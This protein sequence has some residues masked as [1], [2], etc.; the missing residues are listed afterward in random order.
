MGYSKLYLSPTGAIFFSAADAA[1][2]SLVGAP[3]AANL[4]AT[5]MIAPFWST[6]DTRYSGEGIFASTTSAG[7]VDYVTF[8]FLATPTSGNFQTPPSA[9][10]AR[11][12][13]DGS[14]QFQYGANLDG[15]AATIGLSAGAQNNFALA[16]NSGQTNLA[17][18]ASLLFTPDFNK[19]LTYF[20]IGAIEFQG[21]SN[22]SALPTI[23]GVANLP[24]QGGATDAVFTSIGLQFSAPL[25]VI[26]AVSAANYQLVAAGADGVFGTSDDIRIALTP[27]YSSAT[28]SV[29]LAL[30][31][32]PLADG[33]YQLTV[34]GSGQLID[35]SGNPL[36]GAGGGN[37]AS[38]FVRLFSVDR[39]AVQPPV[40]LNG[41]GTTPSNATISV[42]LSATDPQGLALTYA[43][44]SAPQHG[45]IQNFDPVAGTFTY[46]PDVGYVG[47]DTILFSAIDSKL[48]SA[49]GSVTINVTAYRN[50]PVA[51]DESAS[52]IAT[53]PTAI[54]LGAYDAQIPVS[55]LKL[56]I[57][58]GPAHGALTITGQN[59][60]SYVAAAGYNGADAFSYVWIDDTI[61]PALQSAPATVSIAVTSVNQPPVTGPTTIA[62]V[63]NKAYV[64]KLADFPYSDPNNA[65]ST[66]LS[67]V[68]VASL[69]N[70]A[71]GALSDNGVA[72]VAGAK[73]SAADIA[74]GKLVFTPAAGKFGA[75]AASFA[76]E[77]VNSGGGQNASAPAVATIDIAYVNQA[78]TTGD[79]HLSV[80]AGSSLTLTSARFPFSDPNTPPEALAG[81]VITSG[82]SAGTLTLRVNGVST[83]VALNQLI[84]KAQLDAGD[85][86]FT[87]AGAGGSSASFGFAVVDVG[88]VANGGH[89]QSAAATVTIDVLVAGDRAPTTGPT[90][91][92][93]YQNRPYV[94]ALADF[95]YSDATDTSPTALKAVIMGTLPASGALTLGGVAVT[96]GQAIA[97]ADIAA[98]KLVYT[99]APNQSGLGLASFSFAV[100]DSGGLAHGG[101]DTSAPAVASVNVQQR[102]VNGDGSYTISYVGPSGA[103][104][105]YYTV[106]YSAAGKSISAVYSD[107]ETAAWT[108]DSSGKL[109]DVAYA[110]VTAASYNSYDVVYRA[111]GR[112]ASASYSD[113]MTATFNYDVAGKLHDIAYAGVTGASYNSYDVV[114]AKGKQVSASYSDGMTAAWSYNGDGSLHDVAYSG[115]V[116]AGYNAYDVLYGADG[117]KVS[118]TYSNGMTAAWTYNADGSLHDVAYA[119]VTGASYNAYDLVYGF[120]GR[121][122]S[123]TYSNGMTVAWTYNANGTTHDVAYAGVYGAAYSSYDIVYGANGKQASASYANGMTQTW[124][125]NSNGALHDLAY[126]GVKGAAYVSY[127][128][129]YGANGRQSSASYANGM[130]Q[131]WSYSSQGI[132]LHVAYA[133]VT[134]AAYASY[135]VAYGAN[136]REASATYS[137]GMTQTWTY[138]SNGTLHDLASAKIGGAPGASSDI[139][140]GAN[141]R[142][143]S[144]TYS[145]G[146]TTQWN[147]NADGTFHDVVHAGIY[148][149]AYVSYDVVYDSRGRQASAIYSNGMTATWTYNADGSVHDIAYANVPG[150]AYTSY[151]VLYGAS[152]KPASATYSNGMTATW[153]YTAD[154]SLHDVA[155]AHVTGLPYDAYDVVYG[156]NGKPVSSTY[157]NSVTAVWSYNADGTR[158]DIAYSG[159]KGAAYTSYDVVYGADGKAVSATF[160]N[161][162]TAAW[163]YHVAGGYSVLYSISGTVN[164]V[165][166][167][168]FEANFDATR[169][170]KTILYFD[171]A[172][173][174]VARYTY[175]SGGK[176]VFTLGET[177]GEVDDAAP[178][179]IA[180]ASALT[181]ETAPPPAPSVT[182]A[183]LRFDDALMFGA[184]STRA[185]PLVLTGALG[186]AP[187]RAEIASAFFLG[188]VSTLAYAGAAKA[189]RR[190]R[191]RLDLFDPIADRWLPLEEED[192]E[193]DALFSPPADEDA[194][195]WHVVG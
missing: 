189:N 32:G 69:P 41:S 28:D 80:V 12:G 91:I 155:Y 70:A 122:V 98:G 110:G 178:E 3:S 84:T 27:I 130:T 192:P 82:P 120:N 116:G 149:A 191:A 57:I 14:V 171:A 49:Q 105:A 124:S 135:D 44:V 45:A 17:N 77:V 156:P 111:D 58:T 137:N 154:G 151:D 158:H 103:D 173:K 96:A 177:S 100:Q 73:I 132:L 83:A 16:A 90:T 64:F 31:G 187:S 139:I 85:L 148:G 133:G 184:S 8:S 1:K 108:Y 87:P 161:G 50:A 30:P 93:A 9:F 102:Q 112:Q 86:V 46:A 170:L 15:I 183:S 60:V 159:V 125:Y 145:T 109:H 166:Y 42:T 181:Q 21:A 150:A 128:V 54:T 163:T 53:R 66:A 55:E 97:A 23:T 61:S 99:P 2:P 142:Q 138:N 107:G 4:A 75:G 180:L 140:Y 48:V 113:G 146:E 185:P 26:S 193:G 6:Q 136:G 38:A 52:A 7:G 22:N 188:G 56:S 153:T 194:I 169:A 36:N 10:A 59:T 164:G 76:F 131:T 168:S 117:K 47:A 89:N 172:H 62:A 143:A 40:V 104:Y 176:P 134:G 152:G 121:P 20:D 68:I 179:D 25:N 160:S 101:V 13:S 37:Q 19:G 129:I 162:M 118:A 186:P 126:A 127:D 67:A 5:T 147:Y 11:L 114:Y 195:D 175:S 81:V 29:T 144:A 33:H 51:S 18:S 94:F 190:L 72:V 35:A 165:S 24:A 115:V 78:P 141:G 167:A 95:P 79:V 71:T 63:E 123:A 157:S 39:S 88:G 43:I 65:P 119:G 74:A 34:S 92:T 182:P 106:L 174:E